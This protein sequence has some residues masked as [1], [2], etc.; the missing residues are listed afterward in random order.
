MFSG[1]REGCYPVTVGCHGL[2]L[3]QEDLNLKADLGLPPRPEGMV[4]NQ[5]KPEFRKYVQW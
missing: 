3:V 4:S 5:S 2:T 1:K